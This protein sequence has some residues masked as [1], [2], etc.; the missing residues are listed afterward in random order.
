MENSRVSHLGHLKW[1]CLMGGA[2]L[3]GLASGTAL[4][5][6]VATGLAFGVGWLAAGG[7]L[8]RGSASA[9]VTEPVSVPAAETA[10]CS[11]PGSSRFTLPADFPLW[12]QHFGGQFDTTRASVTRVNVL[13]QSGVGEIGSSFGAIHRLIQGQQDSLRSVLDNL[14]EGGAADVSLHTLNQEIA[15]TAQALNGFARLVIEVS[16]LNMD[17]YFQV[18]DMAAELAGIG[19]FVDGVEW[20]AKR[21]TL[22]ALN[23][24]I[25]AANVGAAGRGFQVVANEIRCLA[26]R[27][28]QISVDIRT[29]TAAVQS[30]VQQ[31][32]QAARQSASQDL[33]ALLGSKSQLDSVCRQMGVLDARIIARM[34]EVAEI[35]SAIEARTGATVRSLQFEDI[36]RQ[37]L[38]HVDADLRALSLT[39]TRLGE[40]VDAAGDTPLLQ[41]SEQILA[42][43]RSTNPHLPSQS[44][45]TAGSIEL[46]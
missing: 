5:A 42:E 38:D 41:L 16:K 26:Q 33:S 4:G 29:S 11:S 28:R 34:D 45:L 39:L 18:E 8:L 13:V 2:A 12:S 3:I 7:R 31:T 44:E 27:S 15:R 1:C 19:K 43:E 46:F 21:T 36:S 22:L 10:P 30:L 37:M 32:Q 35:S 6:V 17:V 9:T 23:A 14:S 25:E 20:V 40:Q 24:S